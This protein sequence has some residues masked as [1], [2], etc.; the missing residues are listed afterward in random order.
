MKL[1][2]GIDRSDRTQAVLE[3]ALKRATAM[4]DEITVAIVETDNGPPADLLEAE[5]EE[6]F[7]ECSIDVSIRSLTGHAGSELVELAERE[8]FDRVIIDGGRRSPLGKIQLTDVAEFVL[9]NATM[10]VTLVR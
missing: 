5:V 4:G 9:L 8:D 6:F 1:L 7:S 10:T 2:V 3:T